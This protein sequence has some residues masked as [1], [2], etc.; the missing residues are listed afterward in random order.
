MLLERI[1]REKEKLADGKRGRKTKEY[2]IEDRPL[3]IAAEG[4]V[5]Y[6]KA[7]M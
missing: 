1:K 5:K 3:K 6:R 2:S 4:K 7:K